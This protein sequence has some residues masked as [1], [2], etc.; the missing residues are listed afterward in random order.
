MTN[1]ELL[2]QIKRDQNIPWSDDDDTL[3]GHIQRGRT[4]LDGLAGDEME[5]EEAGTETSLLFN[6]VF[7]ARANAL[8][9]FFKN[10]ASELLS[11]QIDKRVSHANTQ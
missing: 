5:Y 7:Y 11:L 1:A 2:S 6:Y 3:F 10:Y 9:E 4:R 8:D